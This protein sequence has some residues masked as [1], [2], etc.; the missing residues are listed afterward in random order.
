MDRP[1]SYLRQVIVAGEPCP[2]ELVAD[3]YRRM[4][5]V[6]LVNE[7]GPTEAAV[8]CSSATLRPDGDV[9][10]GTPVANT[11]LWVLD[12]DGQVLP[13][14]Q[15]GEVCVAGAGLADGGI[16]GYGALAAHGREGTTL[17]S[18][19][20]DRRQNERGPLDS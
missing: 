18:T 3:H 16:G 12:P 4:P 17:A 9:V 20:Y 5:E 11:Q 19:E 6:E 7:Y 14:G 8:W 13:P 15:F 2:P 10:I 1:S